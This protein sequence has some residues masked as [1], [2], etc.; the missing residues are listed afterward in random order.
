LDHSSGENFFAKHEPET[1]T[2]TLRRIADLRPQ[3]FAAAFRMRHVARCHIA[4]DVGVGR[5]A[6]DVERRTW[7]AACG[8][9]LT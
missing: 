7:A 8:Q 3:Q 2:Q 5:R 9:R 4:V 6:G 1:R